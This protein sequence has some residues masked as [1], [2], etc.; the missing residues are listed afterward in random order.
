MRVL[1]ILPELNVGGVETGT[2]DFGKYLVAHNH[3]SVV[4]SN[5]GKLVERLEKCGS[6]HYTL[7]VHKKSL[8]SIIYLIKPLRDIIQKEKVDIV[9]A[10]SRVPAWIAYFACQKTKATFITTCHGAYNN[11]WFSQVMG[12]SKLM[13]VPSNAIA[14]HMIERYKVT[15]NRLR[16]IPRSVDMEKFKGLP[17]KESINTKNPMIIVIGRLTPIKGHRYFLQAMVPI[18]QKFPKTKIQIVGDASANKEEY[19]KELHILVRR[20]GLKEHVAFL[21]NRQDVPELLAK[22]DVLVFPSIVPESFGR[23]ILEAQM[24]GVPV[25]ATNVGGVVDIID[26]EKTG[27]L[28]M[29]KDAQGITAAVER[30]LSDQEFVGKLTKAAKIKL[31]ANFTLEHMASQTLKVYEEIKELMNILVIKISAMGD[32]ILV[33]PS[34]RALRKKFPQAHI[35][36][37]VGKESRVILKNCPYIDELIIVDFKHKDKGCLKFFKISRYLHNYRFDKVID[38]QNNRKSHLLSFLSF[39][40]SSYGY[41]NGKWGRLLMHAIKNDQTEISPIAHQFR[42]LEQIGIAY[43]KKDSILELWPSKKDEQYTDELLEA[44]WFGN[45]QKI[46]G[47]NMAASIKWGTKNWPVDHM[48]G[49][50]DLL[51]AKNIRVLITGLTKDQGLVDQLLAKTKA[52]PAVLIGKTNILQLAGLIKKCSIFLTPDSA[53]MHVAAAVG[54][55]CIAFFGPTSSLRHVVPGKNMIIMEKNLI[56]SPCYNTRCK[57]LTHACMVNIREEEVLVQILKVLSF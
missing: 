13:I 11:R 33:V 2:V 1:Q 10:R 55:P 30:L 16:C 45:S 32:V 43:H 48:A 14:R 15:S 31:E 42:V 50:C 19:K 24:V 47:I 7:A 25:V 23:V 21:G 12:W 41:D 52:K 36:C 49:L 40:K 46:V 18:V 35:C 26:D 54:T 17:F 34:L 38:F 22:S 53:P 51:A 37:L 8:R 4:V 9:H 57:I 6:K 39:S 56:C 3:H 29:P 20:L 28:V 5:G 27:L 44:A